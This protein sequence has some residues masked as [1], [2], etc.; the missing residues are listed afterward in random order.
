[1]TTEQKSTS[2]A[3]F[4]TLNCSGGISLGAYMAGVF[5][6]LTREAVKPNPKL[7]IDI[8]TGASAGAMSGVLAA[9][10]LLGGEQLS[11]ENDQENTD[12]SYEKSVFY[13]AWVQQAD[14]QKIDSFK[15]ML[16][17]IV[18]GF[19]VTINSYINAFQEIKASFTSKNSN[20]KPRLESKGNLSLLSGEA[21]ENIAQLVGWK[22]FDQSGQ[23]VVDSGKVP[24]IVKPDEVPK[25]KLETKPLVLLMTLTNLQGLLE[26]RTLIN[27]QNTLAGNH[28]IKEIETITSA[29]TR[30]FHFYSGLPQEKMNEM[31]AKAVVGGLASGAFP[32][33]FPPISDTSNI[34]S[35]NLKN[36][37][38]DYFEPETNREKL[39]AQELEG[40]REDDTHLT[41]LYSDG[42]I[43]N[44][45]PLIRGIDLVNQLDFQFNQPECDKFQQEFLKNQQ[46]RK[47]ERLHVYIRPIPVE[48]LTSERRL[49]KEYF[50]MFEVALSALTLPRAEHDPIRLQEIKERNQKVELK[51]QILNKLKT[52]I[53]EN[54]SQIQ[55]VLEEVIPEQEIKLSPITPAIIHKIPGLKNHPNYKHL[56]S[57]YTEFLNSIKNRQTERAEALLTSDFLGAFGGFFDKRYREHDFLIGRLSGITWLHLYCD[58]V[59][60]EG[61]DV[62]SEQI[63]E[64]KI[65]LEEDPT[66]SNLK[67]SQKIRIARIF[68]RAVRILVIEAKVVGTIWILVLGILK[69]PLILTIA[70]LEFFVSL[71]FA[72]LAVFGL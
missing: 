41:F 50:S 24:Q 29:E 60:V 34:T 39:K 4:I 11:T 53:D 67:L 13:Q 51:Q 54:L 6:E 14:I 17:S 66:P 19:K 56:D 1:M 58:N 40:I 33:A 61:L 65:L 30:V 59:E 38:D 72:I 63:K 25:T 15:V 37:S 20:K 70:L 26:K 16:S 31:W 22:G 52:K 18:E 47:P 43:L 49:T 46:G 9:Y 45:L 28:E 10:C 69:L 12:Y 27:S 48:A 57:I 35:Q 32:V 71:I 55:D 36:L 23:P 7:V 68:L 2:A 64:K 8:I 62:L 21:I 42:G 44:G 5:Y 3:Q